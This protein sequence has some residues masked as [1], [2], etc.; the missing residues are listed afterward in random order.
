MNKEIATLL[1]YLEHKFIPD[2]FYD[3]ERDLIYT[4]HENP[5]LLFDVFSMVCKDHD[6]ENPFSKEEFSGETYSMDPEKE[7]FG[8]LLKFPKPEPAAPHCYEMY[9][10]HDKDLKRKAVFALEAAT[11][12]DGEPGKLVSYLNE[13]GEM[14][15]FGGWPVDEEQD[16]FAGSLELYKKILNGEV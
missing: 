16:F 8:T 5:S 3:N 10:F 7:W 6:Q 9:L 14:R 4:L 12:Q 11:S 2:M 1:A 13:Q 15:N